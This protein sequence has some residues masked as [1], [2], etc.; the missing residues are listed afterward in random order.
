MHGSADSPRF[1]QPRGDAHRAARAAW[2]AARP[3]Q[4]AARAPAADG[5]TRAPHP[6]AS[7]W[8]PA[9]PPVPIMP[10]AGDNHRERELASHAAGLRA[11]ANRPPQGASTPGS[12]APIKPFRI[13][14]LN[15]EQTAKPATTAP[16]KPFRT[17]PLNREPTAQPGPT[18]PFKPSRIDP[19]TCECHAAAPTVWLGSNCREPGAFSDPR[20]VHRIHEPAHRGESKRCAAHAEPAPQARNFCRR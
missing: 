17:D 6:N 1:E 12:T 11:P 15:R 14:P 13:D 9:P 8:P 10:Y 5:Q 18:V 2:I 7:P 3:T 4:R 16:F 19:Y 20:Q